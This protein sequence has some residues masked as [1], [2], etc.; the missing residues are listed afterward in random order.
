MQWLQNKLR[1][2]PILTLLDGL[3]KNPQ[4]R[5]QALPSK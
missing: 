3:W 4:K 5:S 2:K 1:L